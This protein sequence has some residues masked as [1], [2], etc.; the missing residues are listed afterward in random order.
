MLPFLYQ[1]IDSAFKKPVKLTKV[2]YKFTRRLIMCTYNKLTKSDIE[3]LSE[4]ISDSERFIT[5][6]TEHWDHDQLKL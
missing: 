6:P 2:V 5:V 4:F 1:L 3:N